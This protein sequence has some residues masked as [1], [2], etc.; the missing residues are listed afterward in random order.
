[1]LVGRPIASCV[2]YKARQPALACTSQ[3][4]CF[5]TNPSAGFCHRHTFADYSHTALHHPPYLASHRAASAPVAPQIFHCVMYPN[6]DFDLPILS[7]DVVA[8][9]GRVSLAII[10]PCPTSPNLQLPPVFESSVKW[11]A[12]LL[13]TVLFGT[14]SCAAPCSVVMYCVVVCRAV[15]WVGVVCCGVLCCL[16]A[17]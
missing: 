6:L 17:A 1:M 14:S 15:V 12:L 10:D 16:L 9:N 3:Q 8:N 7:M 2:A 4:P 5:Y 11:V 13:R